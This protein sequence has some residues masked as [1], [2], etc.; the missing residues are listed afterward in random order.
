MKT[1]TQNIQTIMKT[2]MK[3]YLTKKRER[4]YRERK[5]IFISEEFEISKKRK[6][7]WKEDAKI[8]GQTRGTNS[9]SFIRVME[10]PQWK[11]CKYTVHCLLQF[12]VWQGVMEIR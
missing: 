5:V 11:E 8:R 1:I 9:D 2:T 12:L 7:D 4:W 10:Y 6:E 3:A